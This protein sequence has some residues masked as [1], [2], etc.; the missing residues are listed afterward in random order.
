MIFRSAP[1][2]SPS[3]LCQNKPLRRPY[4]EPSPGH[5]K[6]PHRK[7]VHIISDS[8]HFRNRKNRVTLHPENIS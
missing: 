4:P 2:D 7:I 8:I 5:T 6:T 3:S 1:N